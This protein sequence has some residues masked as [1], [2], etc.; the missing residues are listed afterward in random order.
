MDIDLSGKTALVTGGSRGIGRAVA[1]TFA[2][3]GASVV[4]CYRNE[5]DDVRTLAEELERLG[6]GSYVAQVDITEEESVARLVDEARERLGHIDILVN[7]AGAVSHKS[8][9]DMEFAEWRRVIDTNLNA[10]YLVTHAVLEAMPAGGSVINIG[11]GVAMVGMVGRTHYAASK[12]GVIGFTRSLCKEAGPR[13][14]RA[15]V[16][17]PGI[18][19]THQVA[20]LTPEQRERYE[21]LAALK[22]LGQPQDM[23]NVALFLASDLASFVTGANVNVDGGI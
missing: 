20:G 5:S 15:N 18:T 21:G 12:A 16:L 1:L 8:L 19:E 13:G 7:N 3:H 9:A 23:A 11:A 6:N 22:R 14:I 2:R 17:T 10:L 4:A